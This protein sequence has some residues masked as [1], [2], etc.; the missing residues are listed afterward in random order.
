M[1]AVGTDGNEV[2]GDMASNAASALWPGDISVSR[3]SATARGVVIP[4]VAVPAAGV[5]AESAADVSV[6]VASA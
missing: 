2:A 3:C 6:R 1:G 4:A 5:N